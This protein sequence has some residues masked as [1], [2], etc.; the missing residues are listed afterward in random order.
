M[1]IIRTIILVFLCTSLCLGQPNGG[2]DTS[3]GTSG[4]SQ[5]S[6]GT[7][8]GSQSSGGNS[9][10]GQGDYTGENRTPTNNPEVQTISYL[11][12]SYPGSTLTRPAP[13]NELTNVTIQ[14]IINAFE[15]I[16]DLEE[17]MSFSGIILVKWIDNYL[18][19]RYLKWM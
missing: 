17:T 10:G 11:L 6:G 4:G 9:G 16:D 18:Q 13:P 14:L 5:P 1:M 12:D 19:V 7:N 15:G 3:G 2:G 8:G